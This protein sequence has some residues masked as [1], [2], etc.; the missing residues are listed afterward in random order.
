[1]GMRLRTKS[2]THRTG[3]WLTISSPVLGKVLPKYLTVQTPIIGGQA[4]NA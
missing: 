1:M 3:C 2:A 4:L